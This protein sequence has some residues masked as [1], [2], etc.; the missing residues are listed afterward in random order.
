MSEHGR[1]GFLVGG[2]QK[3]GTTALFHY[4]NDLAGVQMAPATM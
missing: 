2:V 3:G 1:L 4:L